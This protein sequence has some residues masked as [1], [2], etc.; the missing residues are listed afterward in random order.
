MD[1]GAAGLWE[2]QQ[3]NGV[4][5]V[6][7][8][9]EATFRS[10]PDGAIRG[11]HVQYIVRLAEMVPLL[12]RLAMAD[13]HHPSQEMPLEPRIWVS[14]QACPQCG[15]AMTA[16]QMGNLREY[17]CHIGHRFGF[18]TLMA[19]KRAVV[20]RALGSAL[21]QSQE[22]TELLGDALSQARSPESVRL[23]DE[24]AKRR[25]EQ[26]VHR[27]LAAIPSSPTAESNPSNEN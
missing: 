15:G 2:I 20:E 9:E 26:D 17:R 3:H 1:D 4:T 16:V 18:E 24:I 19:E 7:D 6:R 10:M 13:E 27:D 23:A 25:R 22:L 14:G 12:T 21:A 11:L 5:I 8:P